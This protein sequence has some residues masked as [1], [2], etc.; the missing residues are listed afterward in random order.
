MSLLISEERRLSHPYY[1]IMELSGNNLKTELHSWTRESIIDW[2]SWNDRNG[3]YKD[4]ES[5]QEFGNT[6]GRAE[7]LEIMTRQITE[8]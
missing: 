8:D 1:K 3:I 7:A 2:L 5:L 6:L 4:E